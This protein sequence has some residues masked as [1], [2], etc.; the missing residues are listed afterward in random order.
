MVTKIVR[1]LGYHSTIMKRNGPGKSHRK[2]ISILQVTEI[3][4]NNEIA[5]KWIVET[6]W[7]NGISCPHCGS[8][9][10]QTKT[11]HPR[12]PYRCRK[13]RKFF[14]AKT[15]TPMADSNIGY[16]VW[17]VALYLMTTG[18]K[19]TASMKLYRDLEI[20]Q[21]TAWYLAHRIRKAWDRKH[22]PFEGPVEAD[23]TYIGGKERNKH[24]HKKLR[25][26]RGTVGKTAVAGIKDRKT[27]KVR[28]K[29]VE[30]VTG[31]TLTGFVTDSVKP[32]A[33]VY[34]D[35]TPAYDSLRNR[36]AVCHSVGQF[37][38]GMAHTNGLESFWSL[39][40]R[41]YHGTYHHLSR[42]HLHR[43]VAE[44]SGRHNDRNKGT[45]DQMARMV[46]SLEG[47][48]LRYRDLVG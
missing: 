34:T 11:T 48:R 42:K 14:S 1:G 44:F 25:A 24:D 32:D 19:G 46:H 4:P 22:A 12:M 29:V 33:L 2:G 17:A 16:R 35:E 45:L 9:N 21:K 31:E 30:N 43:Y 27:G 10:V 47:K 23:E 36:R 38:D 7:P 41:G 15:G 39:M 20:T 13:C 3:F 26:G 5:E 8:N 28:A 37:V 18:I 40:K 6:R